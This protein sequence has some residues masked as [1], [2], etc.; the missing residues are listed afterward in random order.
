MLTSEIKCAI[1]LAIEA[2]IPFVAYAEPGCKSAVFFADISDSGADATRKFIVNG[3][4][5][6]SADRYEICDS[7]DAKSTIEYLQTRKPSGRPIVKVWPDTTSRQEYQVAVDD[8]LDYLNNHGGKVVVSRTITGQSVGVDWAEVADRYFDIHDE[9]F[10][11]I[12]FTPRH[13]CW[14][15]A[16][17][18]LLLRVSDR[19]FMT[20]ALA[21]TRSISE[22]D[23]TWSG[24]NVAEQAI[25]RNYIVDRLYELGLDPHCSPTETMSTG[26]IQ[27]LCT[28]ITGSTEDSTPEE[29]LRSLNPTPALAGYPLAS[30]LEL[31]ANTERH[32]GRCYGGYIAIATD[33]SFDAYVNLRCVNFDSECWCMYV[34]S[35]I[36]PDSDVDDEW[37]ET[38]AKSLLLKNIIEDS[39][40]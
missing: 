3:W 15:G 20:M 5:G 2:G 13:G 11:Y 37:S 23:E 7:A 30:A 18:E 39:R 4:P 9:A 19:H 22:A 25:V 24:K 17:P 35:G 40:K 36:M 10:R 8:V 31:I 6:G 29:I 26:N 27:H 38:E 14:L 33:H 28:I 21:G 1:S 34:G 12:Y 16:S 32:P